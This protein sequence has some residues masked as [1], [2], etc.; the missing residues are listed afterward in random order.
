MAGDAVRL[1]RQRVLA[2][3]ITISRV[4][5]L[6]SNSE[7]DNIEDNA[8]TSSDQQQYANDGGL[9]MAVRVDHRRG[10]IRLADVNWLYWSS[11]CHHCLLLWM[12]RGDS[13]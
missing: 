2:V 4:F 13:I 11:A 7:V 10:L 12:H 8:Q 5:I 1:V 9:T 3:Q 6:G